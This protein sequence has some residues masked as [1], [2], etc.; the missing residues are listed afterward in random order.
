MNLSSK[1]ISKLVDDF[2]NNEFYKISS[3]NQL[4]K[5]LNEFL[6]ER[7]I[8]TSKSTIL[9]TFNSYKMNFKTLKKK[10]LELFFHILL[11][12]SVAKTKLAY[13]LLNPPKSNKPIV[14][15]LKNL[16]KL[17]GKSESSINNLIIELSEDGSEDIKEINFINFLPK[18]F[19][20]HPKAYKATQ[21]NVI[22][23]NFIKNSNQFEFSKENQSKVSCSINGTS[24]LQL[25]IGFFRLLQ[26]AAYRSFRESFSANSETH[27]RAYDLPYSIRDFVDFVSSFIE[28]YLSLGIIKKEVYSVFN[29]LKESVIKMEKNLDYRMDNWD[30]ITKNESMLH[31]EEN[32]ES[33]FSL[34]ENHHQLFSVLIE[35]VLSGALHGHDPENI[36]I[37]D[38]E[39]HEI[40]RLRHLELHSEMSNIETNFNSLK[41]KKNDFKDSWQRV[42]IDS[43]NTFYKGSIIPTSYWYEEFM[44]LLLKATFVIDKNDLVEWENTSLEDLD[45]WF[46]NS[47]KKE[48][49]DKFGIDVKKHF[50]NLTKEKKKL[51]KQAWLISRH[52]LNGIQ[53]RRERLEFGRETG[54]LSQYVAFID[55]YLGRDDMEKSQMRLSF[56]YFIGPSTWKLL[57]TSAEIIKTQD[58]KNESNSISKFKLFFKS[59][60]TM[61]PCPYCRYHLN[62]F[63]VKNKEISMYPIEYLLLGSKEGFDFNIS[64]QDK[65]NTIIDGKTL[66]LFLWKLHNTVSSSIARTEEWFHLDKNS[67]YTS[68]YWPS[69][70]S[71]LER[72]NTLGIPSVSTKFISKIYG[73]I[74][75]SINLSTLKDELIL[76]LNTNKNTKN[77]FSKS[78]IFSKE[79]DE[80]ILVSKYLEDHY[81]YNAS[82]IDDD[83]HFSAV[84]ES[85]ARSGKFIDD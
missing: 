5:I 17:L 53:K 32:L 34:L 83:P 46:N 65:I 71:E 79:M 55:I 48:E 70:D 68:R 26:G 20:S 47:S 3:N 56:P 66:S 24:T 36:I 49:F 82:N 18:N 51:I 19:N 84:E 40:N 43:S 59:L 63:V 13:K 67:Y 10:K 78:I 9:T 11:G 41:D 52:Y 38:L 29:E 27:L 6:K 60:A 15:K 45:N 50:L 64:I 44:P 23:E 16:L 62:K 12:S 35:F 57:H 4:I 1:N 7:R 2:F 80:S 42:I 74:R 30:T 25:Q 21:Q 22:K 58:I 77:I 54:F 76:Y 33:E 8:N 31:A 73:I 14:N 69:L 28:F 37:E 81:S 75:H 39:H 72:A 61:Y 85:L